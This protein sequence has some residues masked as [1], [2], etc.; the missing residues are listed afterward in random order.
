MEV[1]KENILK[2]IG[3]KNT[4]IPEGTK[5]DFDIQHFFNT[6][7]SAVG[8]D[9]I[10]E[11]IRGFY[12]SCKLMNLKFKANCSLGKCIKYYLFLF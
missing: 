7:A 10:T 5:L 8:D 9:Q 6:T 11:K 4:T 1:I 3:R 12:P 2:Q